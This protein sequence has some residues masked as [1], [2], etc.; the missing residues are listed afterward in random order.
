[1]NN[2]EVN[3]NETNTNVTPQLEQPTIVNTEPVETPVM[4]NANVEPQVA[5]QPVVEQTPQV[6]ETPVVE[7]PQP[8]TPQAQPQPENTAIVN[9]DLKKVEVN[10]TPPSKGKSIAL[11]LFFVFLIAFVIF[12]PEI[13]E[14]VNKMKANKNSPAEVKITDG[15]MTCT[16]KTNT[17]NLDKEYR[18][19][20]RFNDNKLEKLDYSTTTK[21][22]PTLDA[23]TLDGLNETCKKL[24]DSTKTLAGISVS[25]D[26]SEGKLIEKQSFVYTEIEEEKIDA[27]YAEAGGTM[28]QYQARQDMDSIEKSMNAA[29]YSCKREA[30]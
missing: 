6:V 13:T 29:G 21:G 23:K 19:V 20:F 24:K 2:N 30:S 4:T 27:A 18:I 12:L 28:P 7:A 1:M 8:Q 5:T 22:D 14:M 9:E 16:N 3:N 11:I 25:C 17:T 10:Y 26:Y 15:K